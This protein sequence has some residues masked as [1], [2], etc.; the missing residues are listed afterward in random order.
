MDLIEFQKLMVRQRL[1]EEE[2][3]LCAAIHYDN[4]LEYNFHYN[5]GV[6]TGFVLC[7]YKHPHIISVLPTNPY[8]LQRKFEE[9]DREVIQKY[10]ELCVKY[11]WQED[12]LTRCKVIQGFITNKGRFVNREEAFQIALKAGQINENAGVDRELFS[13]DL[14]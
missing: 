1:K 4:G 13:E 7:G 3:I 6:K 11:G 5:Y 14:Y 12:S 8:W 10:E 9:N 2:C